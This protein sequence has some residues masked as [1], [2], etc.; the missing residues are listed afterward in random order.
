MCINFQ[1][2][3]ENKI[4]QKKFCRTFILS[5]KKNYLERR[6]NEILYRDNNHRPE[7]KFCRTFIFNLIFGCLPGLTQRCVLTH[8]LM[9]KTRWYLKN[10]HAQRNTE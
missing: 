10:S 5:K 2:K 6:Q 1:W 9:T 3:K 4:V 8:A 7:V